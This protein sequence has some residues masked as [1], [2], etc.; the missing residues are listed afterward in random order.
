[1][2]VCVVLSILAYRASAAWD[3]TRV[4]VLRAR[5]VAPFFADA[6]HCD[7]ALPLRLS[8]FPRFSTISLASYHPHHLHDHILFAKHCFVGF[9]P[10]L[11]LSD[12]LRSARSTEVIAFSKS[13][14]P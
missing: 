14:T 6:I 10:L 9:D 4:C 5:M 2:C 13:T 3:L 8:P 12:Q 11:I 1:M 7:L